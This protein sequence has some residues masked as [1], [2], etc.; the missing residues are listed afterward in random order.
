MRD[1]GPGFR[2][3]GEVRPRVSPA[4]TIVSLRNTRSMY[5]GVGIFVVCTW[6]AAKIT[7]RQYNEPIM[8]T[9]S[10][11]CSQ[12]CT[13]QLTPA[14]RRAAI[15]F[16]EQWDENE[17]WRQE[18]M[19]EKRDMIVKLRK[20]KRERNMHRRGLKTQHN[21]VVALW[22]RGCGFLDTPTHTLEVIRALIFISL[23]IL[24]MYITL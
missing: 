11:T 13:N 17:E 19:N 8:P 2:V 10:F 16:E 24:Y 22:G 5:P 4:C 23:C 12:V 7:Q 6:I 1:K 14:C 21:E 15:E 20:R 18:G 3:Q 9:N